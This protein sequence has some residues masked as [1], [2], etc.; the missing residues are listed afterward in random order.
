MDW[1]TVRREFKKRW[2]LLP[3]PE[4]D[5]ESK[6]EELE[7]M[8]LKDGDLGMK[9]TYQGQELYSHITFASQTTHLANE[10]GNTNSFLLPSVRNW[11]P[12]AVRNTLKSLGKKPRTW[13]EFRKAMTS[14]PLSDLCKEA[15]D[16]ARCDGFYAEV[17][18]L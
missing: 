7:Q 1:T 11:L 15:A 8:T 17:A 14:I 13:E 16:I 10:I 2:P 5:L 4:E 3:E 6:R 18:A 12:E 9:V